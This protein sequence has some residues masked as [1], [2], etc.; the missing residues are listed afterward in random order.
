MLLLRDSD[1]AVETNHATCVNTMAKGL[2]FK[3]R[4]DNFFQNN[5]HMLDLTVDLVMDAARGASPT[6]GGTM[7]HLINC[8]CRFGLFCIG[9]SLRFDTCIGIKVNEVAISK[10]RENVALNGVR[11][12]DFV[13]MSAK[14]IFSS[15]MPVGTGGA[16]NN[17]GGEDDGGNDNEKKSGGSLVQDFLRDMT[18]V[19]VDPP[20]KG[21]SVEFLDQLNM[22]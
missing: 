10:A 2:V 15:E 7:T 17:G 5:P 3:F 1:G 6:T 22:Y 4:A 14:A 19:V 9:P 21:C 12:R 20:C 18:V 13:A 16:I 8:Y 11:N